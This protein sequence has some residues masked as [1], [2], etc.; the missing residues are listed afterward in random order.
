[1]PTLLFDSIKPE[2]VV[3]RSG[4]LISPEAKLVDVFAA[5]KVYLTELTRP[6][7]AKCAEMLITVCEP[8]S[9]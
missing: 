9:C 3:D 8:T 5:C 7:Y 2:L 4:Q 1:M 6:F